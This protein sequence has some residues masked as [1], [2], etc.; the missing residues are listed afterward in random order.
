MVLGS[1]YCE[2]SANV[3]EPVKPK[4]CRCTVVAL[5]SEENPEFGDTFISELNFWRN[6]IETFFDKKTNKY[7]G[8]LKFSL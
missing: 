8:S 5:I 1:N 3:S 6:C 4:K 7:C 2:L